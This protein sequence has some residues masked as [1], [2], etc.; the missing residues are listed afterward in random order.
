MAKKITLLCSSFPPEKGAAPN[1]MYQLAV[2][3][4]AKNYEVTVLCAMPNYPTGKIF[5]AYKGK[6]IVK[7]KVDGINVIRL[8]M[9][10]T[11]SSN[12]LKRA[13]SLASYALSLCTLGFWQLWRL[14]SSIIYMSSPP[15]VT[16]VIGS[17]LAKTLKRKVV[18]NI[19]DLWPQSAY[20]LGFLKEGWLY[21][22][23]Q[24]KEQKM[25]CRADAFTVQSHYIHNHILAS[26][27]D[28]NVMLYRNLSPVT[29]LPNNERPLGKRIIVYAGLLGIAQG[30]LR[31]V[32]KIN[33]AQLGTELHI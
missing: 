14:P 15:F 18:L 12:K 24:K 10:P 31:I 6:I 1:R 3:L 9:W 27:P 30:V 21:Q 11:N 23:L 5:D 25:Y 20:D 2:L 8:W 19:S 32:Q 4:L 16:G 29:E 22:L 26:I 13:L 33:F 28:A 17:S 7:E